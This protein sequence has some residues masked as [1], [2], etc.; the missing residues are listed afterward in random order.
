MSISTHVLDAVAGAPASGHALRLE[1]AD[2]VRVGNGAA[3][4]PT[5]AVPSSPRGS[6][7]R[8]GSTGCAS[9]PATG[10]P[11]RHRRPS[12]PRSSSPSRSPTRPRTTTCRC[13]SARSATPPT[14]GADADGVAR[15]AAH[16]GRHRGH[17][18][19]RRGAEHAPGHVVVRG[20]RIEASAPARRRLSEPTGRAP[21]TGRRD[22]LPGHARAGQHPPPPLPVGHPRARGRRRA[23]RLADRALPGLGRHR[24]GHHRRRG[25]GRARLAGAHR[26]HHLDGP[27]LRLPD[28]RR[29]RAR[30][31]DRGRPAVGL[32]FLA[33]RGSMDLGQSRGGLPPDHVV[34]DLDAI[35][36]ATAAARRRQHHD[37]APTR[38]CGSAS[39]PA[40]RSR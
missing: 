21:S 23:V 1:R 37:P 8:R 27:P 7:S 18:G 29:R 35:L 36:A 25:G 15:P 13:C 26:L 39:P 17:D 22:R 34:E 9:R 6:S 40:R 14:G 5:G 10:S 24:R 2:G 30:R 31:R 3:P 12:T 11:Q 4:T 33:T 38:C 32:R 16:R 20:G 19:R 28:R